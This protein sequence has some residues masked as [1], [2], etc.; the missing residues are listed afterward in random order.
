MTNNERFVGFID[1]AT[2][3][4]QKH[5]CIDM[6]A[7]AK[8]AL[9]DGDITQADYDKYVKIYNIRNFMALGNAD[10]IQIPEKNLK[11]AED[12]YTAICQWEAKKAALQGSQ[13]PNEAAPAKSLTYVKEGDYVLIYAG[14]YYGGGVNVRRRFDV[15]RVSKNRSLEPLYNYRFQFRS[16]GSPVSTWFPKD[17]GNIMFW[18]I[19]GGLPKG[20]L[21][22]HHMHVWSSDERGKIKVVNGKAEVYIACDTW[23]E[24]TGRK[25]FRKLLCDAR[26]V[27]PACFD[28]EKPLAIEEVNDFLIKHYDGK[29]YANIPWR[30]DNWKSHAIECEITKG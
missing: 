12:F 30:T 14:V 17:V 28:S 19:P 6:L 24:K 23:D 18:L 13:M 8:K 4:A 11:V 21:S 29:Y 20:T 22:A 15:F 9:A 2:V 16:Y 27:L 1:K 7:W 25:N 3:I 10:D 26:R 5:D